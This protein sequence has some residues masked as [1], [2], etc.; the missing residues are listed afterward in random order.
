[1]PAVSK[2][3]ARFMNA[4]KHSP[5]FA[6]E[7]GV[8]QSVGEEFSVSGG[9]YKSLPERKD[10]KVSE[11]K[12]GWIKGSKGEKKLKAKLSEPPKRKSEDERM[13]ARYGSK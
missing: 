13:S 6:K 11:K 3:Q 9:R 8:P 7:A 1:M 12:K 2:A 4:V 5:G 10:S